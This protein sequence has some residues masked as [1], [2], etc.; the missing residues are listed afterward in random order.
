LNRI[1]TIPE[2]AFSGLSKLSSLRLIHNQITE[3]G[4]T[5]FQDLTGLRYLEL[6][7]NNITRISNRALA[8]CTELTELNLAQN[9]IVYDGQLRADGTPRN[10]FLSSQPFEALVKLNLSYNIISELDESLQ[11]LFLNLV[12]LDLSHN[13]FHTFIFEHFKFVKGWGK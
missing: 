2:G 6:Q 1:K 4:D 10:G 8:S 11:N 7:E 5:V 9:S 13:N 3:L 12:S